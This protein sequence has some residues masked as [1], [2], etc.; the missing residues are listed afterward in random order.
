MGRM[1]ERFL[2]FAASLRA[3]G[4][5][6]GRIQ[7]VFIPPFCLFVNFRQ[8]PD[9]FL[10][11]LDHILNISWPYPKH[12]LKFPDHIL[13]ISWNLLTF[14]ERFQ[15]IRIFSCHFLTIS[16]HFLISLDNFLGYWKVL[17]ST[18]KYPKLPKSTQKY[19]KVLNSTQKYQKYPKVPKKPKSTQKY[20]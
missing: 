3:C 14:L 8:Y 20:Q 15:T 13:N 6:A 5:Q 11:F 19:S 4:A 16:W 7:K 1:V 17:K 9:N 18:E 2:Y 12:F 10:T